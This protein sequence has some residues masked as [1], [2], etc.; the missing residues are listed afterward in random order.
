[1]AGSDWAEL[2]GQ[3]CIALNLEFAGLPGVTR[4]DAKLRR[5]YKPLTD[6]GVETD[7][8]YLPGNYLHG[9]AGEFDPR[10]WLHRE[11]KHDRWNYPE[12]F[13]ELDWQRLEWTTDLQICRDIPGLIALPLSRILSSWDDVRRIHLPAICA[14]SVKQEHN[15]LVILPQMWMQEKF[16]RDLLPWAPRIHRLDSDSSISKSSYILSILDTPGQVV[17]GGQAAWKLGAWAEFD[18]VVIIDPSHPQFR[19]D[20]EPHLDSREALLASLAGK[21]TQL[22]L[23]EMGLS[24]FD[25]QSLLTKLQIASPRLS[26]DE[27]KRHDDVIDTD[28]LPLHLRQPGVRRLVHFNRLG[29]SHGLRCADCGSKVDCPECGSRRIHFSQSAIAYIC[30]ECDFRDARLRCQKCGLATLS[31]QFP[32]LEAVQSRKGDLILHAGSRNDYELSEVSSVIGTSILLE[33]H[34]EFKPEEIIHVH[35][36]SEVGYLENWPQEIDMLSRLVGL[37]SGG[38][39]VQP[40]C[41]IVSERLN[42]LLGAE[43]D[44]K[45][46]AGKFMKEMKLRSLALLPPSGLVYRFRLFTTDITTADRLR[47]RLGDELKELRDTTVLRLGRPVVISGTVRLSGYFVNDALTANELQ[48]IRW[49]MFEEKGTLSIQPVR[50]PWI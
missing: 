40:S 3:A 39:T 26:L 46:I 17:F 44:C 20:N 8:G 18:E 37:Y 33:P 28:P 38:G 5:W 49:K 19:A 25:G 23:I 4:I 50:G 12:E 6:L 21:H 35:A 43:L 42:E 11:Q 30:P 31:T 10:S 41:Y 29:S 27:T 32:G 45:E 22:R 16:W 15:T 14:T 7:D 1:M 34:A 9:F 36:D 48:V 13:N 2:A 24:A 47:R